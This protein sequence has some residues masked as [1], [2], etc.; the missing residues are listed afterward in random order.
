MLRTTNDIIRT[1]L[2]Q[3]KL[4]PQFWVEA[5]DTAN[6]LLNIRPSRAI[7]HDTPHFRLFQQ[8]PT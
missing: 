6:H 2:A 8:H 5:L 1:L 4:P 3:S 7:N